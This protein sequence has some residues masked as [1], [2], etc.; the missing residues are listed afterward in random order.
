MQILV[1]WAFLSFWRKSIVSVLRTCDHGR[2][3]AEALKRGAVC[4]YLALNRGLN[5][6]SM[7]LMSL[8]NVVLEQR[9]HCK[10][11]GK[12]EAFFAMVSYRKGGMFI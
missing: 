9:R 11:R 8:I 7:I 3:I 6:I 4:K 5:A 2:S 1:C 12:Y 10:G